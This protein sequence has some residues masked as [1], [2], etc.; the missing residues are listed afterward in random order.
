M[1][2][3]DSDEWNL[4][5]VA[6]QAQRSAVLLG[7]LKAGVKNQALRAMAKALRSDQSEVLE[8]NTI[9]LETGRQDGLS[10]ALLDRLKLTP[11]R[12]EAMAVA[13]EQIAALKDPIGEVA[14]GWKHPDGMEIRRV[15]VPLGVIGIIY[16]A[17]PNVTCDAIGLCLKSGNGVLLKGGREAENSNQAITRI[18][19]EA[20]YSSGIPQGCIQQLPG[21][22]RAIVDALIRLDQLALL[23]PRGGSGLIDYVVRNATVPVLET[24]VGNCHIYIERSADVEMARRI[25]LNAKVQRPSVCNAAEKLLIHRDAVL[26][27]L[28]LV[29]T[30]LRDQGV[31]IRGCPRTIAFDPRVKPAL[32]EDW[33]KE[34]LDKIIAVKIVDSTREAIDWINHYGSRHSEAI[35]TDNYHEAV[36]FT[37]GVDAAAVY[38]NAS[39]RFTDGGEF[40]F[41]AEIGISTQ[42]LHARGPVGLSE[43]TTIKYIVTGSGQTR[44]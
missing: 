15:R 21:T 12:I 10:D 44:S 43:L 36:Q 41:G 2:D 19:Q 23:I 38:V 37:D 3:L 5:A 9:D 1:V 40:G 6:Q 18:L 26:T 22:D 30:S 28:E 29:L 7:Q 17:R 13:L 34:Y 24:G 31:E 33:G 42:K 11:Q 27:H 20:A 8:A 25:V 16:E 14:A 4:K 35:V 32:E 39:T